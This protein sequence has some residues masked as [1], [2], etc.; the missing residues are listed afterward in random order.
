[1][2]KPSLFF[3]AQNGRIPVENS[4][5]DFVRFGNGK[6]TLVMIP[7][8]GDGLSSVKGMALIFSIL[9]RI[10]AKE[11][12]VYI[13][14]RKNHLQKGCSTRNMARDQARAMIALGISE[15]DVV[16]I[17]L[18]G[19]IAQYLAIDFPELVHKLVLAVTTA[20][21]N[22]TVQKAAGRWMEMAEKGKYRELMIDTAENSYSEKYLKK[23]R[24]L[25][26]FLGIIGK[27]KS[28][29]R[30]LIQA[31]SCLGHHAS[32]ELDKISCPVLVIGADSD[33]IVGA[34]AAPDLAAKIRSSQLLIYKGLGHAA[35][36]E[37]GDF[38]EQVFNFLTE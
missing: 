18:G 7:G 1:M 21:S 26:P 33:R 35:Y 13:F 12:T 34:L 17:S 37:A 9:Y 24:L 3:S 25:Y 8:L 11:F 14:S 27:P 5:M 23:Y 30:F 29:D 32:Q 15:A 31:A 2:K 10:Y 22:E 36:E 16:G 4:E 19:M 6:K 28:F 38:N 20:D